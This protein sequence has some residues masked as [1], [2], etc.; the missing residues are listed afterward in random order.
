MN[1]HNY[2]LLNN[3]DAGEGAQH[4]Y[5]FSFTYEFQAAEDDEVWFAHAIPYTYTKLS[6]TL[7]SFKQKFGAGLKYPIA[8]CQLEEEPEQ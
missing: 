8:A 5:T 2:W 6:E 4:Y 1:T 3:N 7:L